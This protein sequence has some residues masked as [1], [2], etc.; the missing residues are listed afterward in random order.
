MLIYVIMI[1]STVW[2]ARSENRNAIGNAVPYRW[3][4]ALIPMVLVAC[5]RYGIGTDYRNYASY[6]RS[7]AA[8]GRWNMELLFYLT[9]AGCMK[10]FQDVRFAFAFYSILIIFLIGKTVHDYSMNCTES[11]FIF[12]TLGYYFASLNIVRQYVSVALVFF[13]TRYIW[14][15]R[16]FMY[17]I[18]ILIAT[19]FHQ[20]AVFALL[21]PVLC[22]HRLSSKEYAV[23]SGVGLLL[24]LFP[25]S[26]NNV[27]VTLIPSRYRHY[28][29]NE[30]SLVSMQEVIC[31]I[32]LMGALFIMGLRL[33]KYLDNIQFD[34]L[35]NCIF[36]TLLIYSVWNSIPN[37]N[38]IG[39]YFEIYTILYI[40]MIIEL[41]Q[42]S[43]RVSN[44]YIINAASFAF[45]LFMI[46][47]IGRFGVIPYRTFW[48]Q[49]GGTPIPIA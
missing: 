14:E 19:L 28:V 40:P 20:S 9:S 18:F 21:I 36:Y 49:F 22:N 48:G 24:L 38:R 4:T 27:L 10:L 44:K 1:L 42:G 35:Y 32:V 37:V 8:G 7:V 43:S 2:I 26:V 17:I 12:I 46:G 33:R 16:Y 47:Y 6:F 34:F 30:S 39:I 25:T 23:I 13:S 3:I 31:Y 11:L 41:N 45:F 29:L 15:K 5:F